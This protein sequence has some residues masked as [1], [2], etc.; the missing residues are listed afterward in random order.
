MAATDDYHISD[1]AL[2]VGYE[3][4]VSDNRLIKQSLKQLR[5]DNDADLQLG[6]LRML[7]R[8][9]E[10]GYAEEGDS[11]NALALAE[12]GANPEIRGEAIAFLT[13]DFKH[14]PK[15]I[16]AVA[17]ALTTEDL[18]LRGAAT[19]LLAHNDD[20]VNALTTEQLLAVTSL[21]DN[22][23]RYNEDARSVLFS[24]KEEAAPIVLQAARGTGTPQQRAGAVD[25]FA[26]MFMKKA[27]DVPEFI[28]LF[29]DPE[30]EVRLAILKNINFLGASALEDD[31]NARGLGDKDDRVRYAAL[32]FLSKRY[33]VYSPI[34]RS[35][36]PPPPP[37]VVLKSLI[38]FIGNKTVKREQRASAT[39]IINNYPTESLP[40]VVEA[41]M[42][43]RFAAC[44]STLKD[45]DPFERLYHSYK[46]FRME[47]SPYLKSVGYKV[48]Y[49]TVYDLIN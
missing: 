29:N 1:A 9:H 23:N 3:A 25:L 43:N 4:R 19:S 7:N 34:Y 39:I 10:H 36:L 8:I 40:Y 28:Q 11:L 20:L 44:V 22:A 33:S 16:P 32:D 12:K 27:L 14:T 42:D 30:P 24:Y 5:L 48:L 49:D 26:N 45:M 15:T 13:A 37:P 21:L 17:N 41:C 18:A 35:P 47:N 38:A 2:T 46:L 6:A 31:Y